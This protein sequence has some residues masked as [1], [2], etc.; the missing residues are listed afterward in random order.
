MGEYAVVIPSASMEVRNNGRGRKSKEKG[1]SFKVLLPLIG[2]C[3]LMVLMVVALMVGERHP[4][5]W[6]ADYDYL[7]SDYFADYSYYDY[8]EP[9]NDVIVRKDDKNRKKSRRNT[10]IK[11]ELRL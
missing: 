10:T 5:R 7:R 3:L 9:Q 8:E 4:R 1:S 11:E 2:C 6:D